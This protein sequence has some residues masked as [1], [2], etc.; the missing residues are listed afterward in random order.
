[1]KQLARV[2]VCLFVAVTAAAQPV[3]MSW[4]T[5]AQDPARV[6]SFRN[7]VAAM[8]ARNTADKSSAEYRT[9]WEYWAN[10]HG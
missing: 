4:Q 3:R 8:R 1:M 10:M 2:L 5:F 7:A 6:Q 9:S